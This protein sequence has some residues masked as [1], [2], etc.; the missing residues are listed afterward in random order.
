MLKRM[1]FATA[2]EDT[3]DRQGR[4]LLPQGLRRYAGIDEEV[5]FAGVGNALELWSR[6]RWQEQ[7]AQ[8]EEQGWQIAEGT[9]E[10]R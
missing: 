5:V 6:E 1:T 7:V 2:N 4:V 9:E 3:L 8:M 10:W